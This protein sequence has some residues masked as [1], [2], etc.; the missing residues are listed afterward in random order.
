MSSKVIK[1][2]TR[3]SPLALWQAH[4][5][6]RQLK[7][8]HSTLEAEI[9]VIKTSGDWN[10]KDGEVRLSEAQG[11]KGLFAKEIEAALIAGHIDIGV[12]SMKDMDSFLPQGLVIECML[13]RADNRDAMLVREDL[14]GKVRSVHDLPKGAVV[15]TASVRRGAFLLAQRPDLKIEPFRG[16]VQTRIDKVRSGQVDATFLALAGLKRLGFD[17]EIDLILEPND[18][19]P[20][21]GQGAVGIEWREVDQDIDAILAPLNHEPTYFAV[22]AERAALKVLD[23][24]CYTPIGAHAMPK[25]DEMHLKVWVSSMDGEK[26]YKEQ[27]HEEICTVEEAKLFG[28][29]LG[30]K[31]MAQLPTGFLE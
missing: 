16:N 15:G 19:L 6:E 31:I 26:I 17:G 27:M 29:T 24:T 5:V 1:I 7:L 13:E 23:G 18:M 25:A 14:R 21:A 28:Q 10:P 4:E 3:G 11:G 8:A 9:V 20:A 30:E 22:M 2:G 12:H